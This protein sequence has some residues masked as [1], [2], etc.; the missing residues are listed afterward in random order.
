MA[1]ENEN[2]MN[3]VFE[4][5]FN[6]A[7]VITVPVDDSLSHSG[8]AADAAAVGAALALK[9]DASA[10]TAIDV[11]GQ[12]A[13]AQG[14]I[15]LNGGDIPMSATDETTI[16]AAVTAVAGRTGADIPLSAD[17]QAR[18]IQEAVEAIDAS[19][20]TSIPMAAGGTQTVAQKIAEIDA[21]N[22]AQGEAITAL[23]GRT[24]ETI[25]MQADGEETVAEAIAGRVK[26]V[27][28]A[29]PDDSGDVTVTDVERA[30]NLKD[31]KSTRSELQ[32]RI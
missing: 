29:R 17:P 2:D 11:N 5:E 28:G 23:Q 22:T 25:L 30:N 15:L 27:N 24:A 31:R 3:E 20:A 14:H 32:S 19:D 18:T 21:A 7:D 8:E 16:A 13:D 1:P 9:A 6:D 12:A 26:T 4:L 10:V